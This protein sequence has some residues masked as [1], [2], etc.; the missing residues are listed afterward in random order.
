MDTGQVRYTCLCLRCVQLFFSS[1]VFLPCLGCWSD[2]VFLKK[3]LWPVGVE[4]GPSPHQCR[5]LPTAPTLLTSRGFLR[6]KA[7][8]NPRAHFFLSFSFFLS[9][10]SSWPD[11]EPVSSQAWHLI[12]TYIHTYDCTRVRYG[13]H[14]SVSGVYNFF[15]LYSF[16]PMSW[17]LVRCSFWEKKFVAGRSRAWSFSSSV[18]HST[19][20]TNAAHFA[21]IFKGQAP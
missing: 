15:F 14:A 6:G 18:S 11:R 1:L 8:K 16:S 2:V 5:T 7:L 19:N 12:H 21:R 10:I 17:L 9:V 13:T 20:C 4:P 3:N